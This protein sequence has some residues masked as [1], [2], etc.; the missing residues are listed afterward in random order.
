MLGDREGAYP[1]RY[2]TDRSTTQMT[3]SVSNP[4]GDPHTH[5]DSSL[6][7]RSRTAEGTLPPRASIRRVYTVAIDTSTSPEVPTL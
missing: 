7:R 1:L 3:H 2:V 6:L 4:S 5:G